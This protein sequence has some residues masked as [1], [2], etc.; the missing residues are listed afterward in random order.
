MY[1][2][3]RP[4]K[5]RVK[6][7]YTRTGVTR[8]MGKDGHIWASTLQCTWGAYY[9]TITRCRAENGFTVFGEFTCWDS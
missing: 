1:H 4:N 9:K 5:L 2:K 6:M 8:M 7:R 3:F